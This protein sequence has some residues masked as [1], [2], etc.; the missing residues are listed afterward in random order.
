MKRKDSLRVL[1]CSLL[2]SMLLIR[3]EL[4][5]GQEEVISSVTSSSSCEAGGEIW[6]CGSSQLAQAHDDFKNNCTDFKYK[7][8]KTL[9]T[10]LDV[11]APMI[12]ESRITSKAC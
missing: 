6:V 8:G 11:C 12:V 7:C 5:V 10:I 2:M 9:K 3:T 1:F 4:I